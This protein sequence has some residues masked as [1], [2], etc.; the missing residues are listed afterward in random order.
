MVLEINCE[1]SREGRVLRLKALEPKRSE[2]SIV[3]SGNLQSPFAA[4]SD[5]V[6]TVSKSPPTRQAV[7]VR[8]LKSRELLASTHLDPLDPSQRVGQFN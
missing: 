3:S 5:G 6:A 8:Q 1:P 7:E 2:K 4:Y